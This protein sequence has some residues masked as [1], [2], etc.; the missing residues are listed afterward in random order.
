MI[1]VCTY[2]ESA[3]IIAVLAGLREHVAS[4]T[5]VV[6]DDES[7][8]GTAKVAR[9]FAALDPSTEVIVRNERGLGGAI[10]RGIA[11]AIQRD[12]DWLINLD[13]DLSHNPAHVP[14]LLA[15]ALVD[16]DA[17][18]VVVGSRYMSG[19]AIVGWPLR[20]RWMSRTVNRF[21][22]ACLRLPV[23]DCSGS[24]RCYRVSSLKRID[25]AILRSNG[26]AV[27]EEILVALYKADCKFAEVPVTYTVRAHG[28]SKL[29]FAEAA[30]SA[31]QIIQLALRR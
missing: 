10:K 19:G 14:R 2:N 16:T 28:T 11:H 1:A 24:M 22:T 29:T 30:R 7:P 21:A 12:F 3:N 18:D 27:L 5:L 31:M 20:R 25:P 6:I 4:A 13:G 8:D 17:P 9:A 15:A 26:Y 23:S